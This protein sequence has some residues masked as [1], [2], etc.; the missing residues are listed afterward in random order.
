MVSYTFFI[1]YFVLKFTNLETT[2]CENIRL[3]AF[4]FEKIF[5]CK[6]YIVRNIFIEVF[7]GSKHFPIL[8][9][10]DSINFVLIF[11]YKLLLF[12]YYIF[13]KKIISNKISFRPNISQFQFFRQN[14]FRHKTFL[15]VEITVVFS[16]N[17]LI[18]FS[19]D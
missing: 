16:T 2:P 10:F 17:I 19:S 7:F 6:I 8:Y 13:S 4:I 11:S 15:W 18:N 3:K 1:T 9:F 14:K 5:Y 12:Y